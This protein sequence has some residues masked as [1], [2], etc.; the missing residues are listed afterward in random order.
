MSKSYRF[1]PTTEI[2]TAKDTKVLWHRRWRA[3]AKRAVAGAAAGLIDLETFV[4][5]HYDELA[6]TFKRAKEVELSS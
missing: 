5:T 4:D 2:N 1:E 3:A 6:N